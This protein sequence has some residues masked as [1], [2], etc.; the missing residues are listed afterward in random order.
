MPCVPAI[1]RLLLKEG[2]A[3]VVRRTPFTITPLTPPETTSPQPVTLGVDTGSAVVG[4]ASADESA[5][6]LSLAEVEVR[7]EIA[8]TMK[9]RASNR[10]TSIKHRRC[11][12]TMRST[13][14]GPLREI[15]D[16]KG[17]NYGFAN[18]RAYVLT[19]ASYRCQRGPGKST[20]RRVEVPHLVFRS[21]GGSADETNLFTLGKTCHD[22]LH[23]GTITLTRTGKQKGP[24][25]H[26][27]QMI[28]KK[29]I[30]EG[31]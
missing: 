6:S 11:S 5:N 29:G 7:N 30:P 26:A 23:A 14:D 17:I 25:A 1:A 4:V 10:R 12:P 27:T 3:K 22:G 19:R 31:D 16:Q 8:A 24:L 2:K 20:D 21:Q 28:L 9:E 13:I 18:T 15:R